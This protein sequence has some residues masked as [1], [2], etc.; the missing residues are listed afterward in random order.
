MTDITRVRETRTTTPTRA[1]SSSWPGCHLQEARQPEAQRV[2]RLPRTTRTTTRSKTIDYDFPFRA[3]DFGADEAVYNGKWIHNPD[4]P[5]DPWQRWAYDLGA[6]RQDDQGTWRETRPGHDWKNPKNEDYVVYGKPV[7]AV[8]DGVVVNAWRNAPENPR[9]FTSD[10]DSTAK[11]L[12]LADKT[13]LHDDMRAGR[14]HGSGNFLVIREDDGDLI[15]YAHA[16]PGTISSA[17]CPHEGELLNPGSWNADSAVPPAQ[18]VRVR[19][20]DLLFLTGNSGHSSAPHLHLDRTHESSTDSLELEFRHG[21]QRP[22]EGVQPTTPTWT[23]FA[24]KQ[25]P[26]PALLRP[27]Y[28]SGGH[29]AWHGLS[30]PRYADLFQHLADSGY[31]PAWLDGY[32]VGGTSYFNA[33]WTPATAPWLSYHRLTASEYQARFTEC[34]EK[35]FGLTHVDSY[36]VGDQVRYAAVFVQGARPSAARHGLDGPTFHAWFE[37]Q[38][39]AGSAP[40]CASVVSVD[41]ALRFTAAFRPQDVGGWVLKP[42]IA[43]ADYQREYEI[44]A[45]EG[46]YPRAVNA[47]K[48]AG[49]VHYCVVFAQK[50]TGPRL[51]RHGLSG[52]E[53]QTQFDDAAAAGMLLQAVAG[54]DGAVRNH[55]YI[56]VW[57]A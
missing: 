1:D 24:G 21:L 7:Y 20:G 42:A 31:Q 12:A 15:H 53:Y 56:A 45:A 13:W 34:T 22:T 17:L 28:R 41:G 50:P 10:K 2:V 38:V 29:Y 9:P 48:H 39:A 14:M 23:S 55:E 54:V 37:E 5:T 51:D 8:S 36:T 16:Q 27:P 30:E 35:G 11:D 44:N 40:M 4:T 26:G 18:R 46:R 57:R 47:Y 19:R 25:I 49:R 6:A 33:V 43:A 3:D 32:S 52:A